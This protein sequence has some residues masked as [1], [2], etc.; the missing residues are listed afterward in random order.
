MNYF[1]WQDLLLRVRF[2]LLCW[3][4][5]ICAYTLLKHHDIILAIIPMKIGAKCELLPKDLYVIWEHIEPIH[6]LSM[7]ILNG[8]VF[9][10]GRLADLYHI[11][12]TKSYCGHL[13]KDYSRRYTSSSTYT[14]QESF[15]FSLKSQASVIGVI[16]IMLGPWTV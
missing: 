7:F 8:N 12:H 11:Y 4:T 15:S 13:L 16:W 14:S 9:G 1:Q 6:Y 3:G 10:S 2:T 5:I